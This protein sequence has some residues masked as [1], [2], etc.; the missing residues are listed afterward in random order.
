MSVLCYLPRDFIEQDLVEFAKV[1][2]GV[3]VYL[4]PR[5]HRGPVVVAEYCKLLLYL[6][7]AIWWW[8]SR[9]PSPPFRLWVS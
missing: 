1:N 3:V 2:P 6:H 8:Q 5:R 7:V 9:M 4:K